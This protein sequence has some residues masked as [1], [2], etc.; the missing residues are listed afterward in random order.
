MPPGIFFHRYDFKGFLFRTCLPVLLPEKQ[1]AIDFST[2]ARKTPGV[3]M[4]QRRRQ[5]VT[6]FC[7]IKPHK[8]R[9][10]FFDAHQ[11]PVHDR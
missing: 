5:K 3:I 9:V 11:A 10:S 8:S 4:K 1:F 2:H 6:C 7:T